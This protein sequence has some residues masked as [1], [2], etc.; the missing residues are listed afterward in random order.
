MPSISFQNSQ[1]APLTCKSKFEFMSF[2]VDGSYNFS[3]ESFSIG[4]KKDLIQTDNGDMLSKFGYSL[5][6]NLGHDNFSMTPMILYQ[7]SPDITLSHSVTINQNGALTTQSGV[8][9]NLTQ[10]K[11]VSVYFTMQLSSLTAIESTQLLLAYNHHGYIFKVPVSLCDE[12]ENMPGLGMTAFIVAAANALV[13]FGYKQLKKKKTRSKDR[14]HR[15]AYAKFASKFDKVN[16]Y[17]KENQIFYQSSLNNEIKS[18]GLVILEAYF[19]LADH[20]YQ[21]EGGMLIYKYPE[22][23]NQYAN[24]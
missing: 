4:V 7:A 8:N 21:I 24:C 18:H 15:V 23:A 12:S 2:I 1:L 3:N 5:N 13:Y 22:D 9:Y 11:G 6:F 20:I 16:H 19:G 17:L 14:E 10:S